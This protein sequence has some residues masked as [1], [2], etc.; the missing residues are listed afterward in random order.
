[1]IAFLSLASQKADNTFLLNIVKDFA[2]SYT[3]ESWSYHLYER[4]GDA[5]E[6]LETEPILDLISWDVT[7]AGAL[8]QLKELRKAYQETFLLIVADRSISPMRYLRPDIAPRALILKPVK[9][10]NTKS[11][12]EDIFK[13]FTEQ[14]QRNDSSKTFHIETREGIQN[15]PVSQIDYFEAKEKKIFLRT[16][17]EEYGFYDSLDELQKRLP[18]SF[19]R[20]HRSYIVNMKRVKETQLSENLLLMKDGIAVPFSRSYKRAIKEYRQHG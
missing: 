7:V 15:V 3:E 8:E 13:A 12:I 5:K 4:L 6:Y 1:M 20:C 11:A 14:L 18:A 2:A 16:K 17:S 10:K 19:F 9:S